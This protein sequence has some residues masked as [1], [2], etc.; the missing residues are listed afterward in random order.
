MSPGQPINDFVSQDVASSSERTIPLSERRQILA[1]KAVVK[2]LDDAIAVAGRCLEIAPAWN[3][4]IPPR[5]LDQPAPLHG[6][7]N[8]RRGRSTSTKHHAQELLCQVQ[9]VGLGSILSHQQ[10]ARQT[11]LGLMEAMATGNLAH[12]SPCACTN[13]RTRA[14]ISGEE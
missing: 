5:V 14:W 11:L 6:P 4:Y 3:F 12:V 13:S 1:V 9:N 2:F 7:R 8:H 10:P